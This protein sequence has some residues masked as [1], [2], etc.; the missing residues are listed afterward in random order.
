MAIM[1]HSNPSSRTGQGAKPLKIL[2]VFMTSACLLST[3]FV[4][5]GCGHLINRLI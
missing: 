1:L 4:L 3:I 2:K 5:A